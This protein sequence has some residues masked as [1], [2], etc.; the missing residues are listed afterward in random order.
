MTY[1]AFYANG[2]A[3]SLISTADAQY[4][5]RQFKTRLV[6]LVD[7]KPKEPLKFPAKTVNV[8]PNAC[9]ISSA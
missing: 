2:M 8:K 4:F 6:R 9:A 1:V 7:E 3:R 5:A